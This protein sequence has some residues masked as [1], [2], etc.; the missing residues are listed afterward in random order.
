MPS[1]QISMFQK[2]GVSLTFLL[3]SLSIKAQTLFS[4][5]NQITDRKEFLRAFARNNVDSSWNEKNCRDYLDLFIR[6]KLK[7]RAALDEKIDSLPQQL[8]E[9]QSFKEQV[10][11]NYM[12]D[13]AS[14]NKLVNQALERS[15]KEIR[16]GHLYLEF[17]NNADA[18]TLSKISK[19]AD[20]LYRQLQQGTDFAQLALQHS[21]DPAVKNNR[22]DL[23]FVSVFTLPYEMENLVYALEPGATAKPYK[24][25]NGFHIFK[26]LEERKAKGSVQVAQILLAFP[27]EANNQQKLEVAQLADSLYEA[28]QVA[29]VSFNQLVSLYSLDNQSYQ[30]DGVLP[31]FTAGTYDPAFENAAFSLKEK[32]D[33]SAPVRTEFGYHILQKTGGSSPLQADAM[34]KDQIRKKTLESDRI[35]ISREIFH[36]K[37][38]TLLAFKQ[39]ELPMVA[40][41]AFSDSVLHGKPKPVLKGWNDESKLFSFKGKNVYLKDWIQ[42]LDAL[43]SFD[44]S[45][46]SKPI[47]ALYNQF[48]AT[49]GT[50]YYREHLEEFNAAYADQIREFREG[51]LLFE[52][53]QRKIWDAAAQ[54]TAGLR[55]YFDHFA[56]KKRYVWQASAEALIVTANS[57][58]MLQVAR[59]NMQK[60]PQDWKTLLEQNNG[61]LLGDS[62]R[63]ELSQLPLT[64]GQS[65][66]AGLLTNPVK[67][68]TDNSSTFCYLFSLRGEGGIRSFEEAKGFVMNDYQNHLE[69]S[70]IRELKKKYPVVVNEKLFEE[71]VLRKG[72]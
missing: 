55:Y 31:E 72:K 12:N 52:I 11:D 63:Y 7:V 61:S 29:G 47:R 40:F 6:F 68:E 22:G 69:E 43:K 15:F 41:L 50:Q 2:T 39:A 54:D 67:N 65:L 42:H 34:F 57:D 38:K 36:T 37:I 3:L 25:K 44:P 30:N 60:N 45:A 10:A 8:Q 35:R 5:G 33:V 59:E 53:M 64:V 13:D 71:L 27:P 26:N 23:G 17:P 21:N 16:L 62:G 1:F 66:K 48:I 18:S 28:L 46:I 14:L 32:G 9:L 70:W 19:M 4:V 51:N 56:D 24:S 49:T 58:S 20:E